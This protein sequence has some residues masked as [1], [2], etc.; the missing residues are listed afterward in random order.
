M[1]LFQSVH[2]CEEKKKIKI[3]K[4]DTIRNEQQVAGKTIVFILEYNNDSFLEEK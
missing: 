2:K 1:L 4:D 3:N